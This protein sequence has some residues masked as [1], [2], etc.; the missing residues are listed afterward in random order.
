[1]INRVTITVTESKGLEQCQRPVHLDIP[2][3]RGVLFD[4]ENIALLDDEGLQPPVKSKVKGY[5]MLNVGT[6]VTAN[7]W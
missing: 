6:L 2:M 3:S 1:M 7:N 5:I 4:A